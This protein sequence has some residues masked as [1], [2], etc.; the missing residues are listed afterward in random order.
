MVNEAR[1]R[2][3][4]LLKGVRGY[5]TVKR[6]ENISTRERWQESEG[7]KSTYAPGPKASAITALH[8]F[9][10]TDDSRW[11]FKCCGGIFHLYLIQTSKEFETIL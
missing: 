2:P 5:S 4:T 1:S 10:I 6:D 7:L 8:R 9:I 3:L 11:T